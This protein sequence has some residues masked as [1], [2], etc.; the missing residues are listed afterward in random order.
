MKKKLLLFAHKG[1]A[2]FFL[3]NIPHTPID[4]FFKG[5][6]NS[7]NYFLLLTGEGLQNASE[8]T[9]SVLTQFN[10]QI[11]SIYNIGTAGSLNEN[12]YTDEIHWI[13][14]VVAG[15]VARREYKT[16]YSSDTSAVT[17]CISAYE[18]ITDIESR[19]QLS[20]FGDI[21]DRELWA[22]GS[23][24]KFFNLPFSALKYIS[25]D[26]KNTDFCADVIKKAPLISEQL[27]REFIQKI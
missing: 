13:K 23:A 22:I 24:A 15:S 7:E 19:R 9:I 26:Y 11:D 3:Q 25:D 21:V 27:Y 5:L 10:H 18:R 20:A 4:F 12:I 17:T 14:S 1:E 2:S 6:F 16:F 8:K